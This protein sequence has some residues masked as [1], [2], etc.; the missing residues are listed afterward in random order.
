MKRLYK[1]RNEKMFAGVCGGIAKYFGV[2]PV[3]VRILFVIFTFFGGTAIIAY[4]V[5]AI[6]MQYPPPETAGA[7]TASTPPAPTTTST[8]TGSETPPTPA[9]TTETTGTSASK[10]S[11]PLVI[12]IILVVIGLFFLMRNI[13]G[14][15]NFYWWIR[16]NFHDYFI[17]GI[18]LII[19][20]VLVVNS[21]RK[22]ED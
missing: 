12:G 2:D 17:P 5:G 18:L 3:L 14:F 22:N 19:G 10:N 13:P 16:W 6:I 11:A 8:A 21:R 20:T 9:S 7:A 4:I 1:S 15:H